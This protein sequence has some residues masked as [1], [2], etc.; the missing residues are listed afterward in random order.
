MFIWKKLITLLTVFTIS[1]FCSQLKYQK[2]AC[3]HEDNS[4]HFP[5]LLTTSN[6]FSLIKNVEKISMFMWKLFFALST[7]SRNFSPLISNQN[8]GK[9]HEFIWKCLLRLLTVSH[10]FSSLLTCDM[11]WKTFFLFVSLSLTFLTFPHTSDF[12]SQF[13]QVSPFFSHLSLFLAI[14]KHLSLY[15]ACLA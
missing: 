6:C 7:V 13:S 2:I 8:V 1:H 12:S 5:L 14:F 3:L 9:I 4:L 11:C 10:Y 15:L